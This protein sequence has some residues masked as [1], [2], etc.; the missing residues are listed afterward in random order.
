MGLR[1]LS[2]M[3]FDIIFPPVL[4]LPVGRFDPKTI[5]EAGEGPNLT[6]Y[7]HQCLQLTLNKIDEQKKITGA[8]QIV[9]IGDFEELSFRTLS[10]LASKNLQQSTFMFKQWC[11]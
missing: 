11:G 2:T 4:W 3:A 10:H 7:L 9:V 6:R 1:I 8:T 5:I